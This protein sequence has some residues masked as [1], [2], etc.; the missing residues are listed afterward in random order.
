MNLLCLWMHVSASGKCAMVLSMYAAIC[1]VSAVKQACFVGL[2]KTRPLIS[3]FSGEWDYL[4]DQIS[5]LIAL[6]D[7]VLA[8]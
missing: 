7:D 5:S 4:A 8:D 6:E 2:L 1:P 3:A